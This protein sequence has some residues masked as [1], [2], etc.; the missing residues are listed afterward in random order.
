MLKIARIQRHLQAHVDNG[1]QT[2]KIINVETQVEAN[3][4]F[5]GRRH[6]LGRQFNELEAPQQTDGVPLRLSIGCTLNC[7]QPDS[8]T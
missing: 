8:P 3:Q 1:Y 7:L 5:C 2:V 6:I 4:H